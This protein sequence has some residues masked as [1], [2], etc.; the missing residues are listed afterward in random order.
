MWLDLQIFGFRALWSPYFMIFVI[1]M[2]LA[3]FLIT[4]PYRHKFDALA[5]QPSTKEQI[6]F[7][8]AMILLYAVKGAPIDL[9]SHIMLTAHMIQM[10]VYYLI[11]PILVL[12]G[13]PEWLWRKVLYQPV[14]K[15]FFK[16]FTM[17]LISLLMF[18]VLF[19]LYHLP[20]VFDFAKSS[21]FAH[22]ATSLI[23]LFAAFIMWFPIVAPIRD[24]DTISPLL[25]IAYIIGGTVLITP[26]CVLIIF[27]DVPLFDAYSAQGSWIQALSLCVPINVLD[28]LQS[29]ISGPSM[30]SPIDIMEDQQLG[31][32]IMKIVQE[33]VYGTMIARIFFKWFSKESLKIDP[34]PSNTP[35]E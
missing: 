18:N 30:F 3:Y 10:A 11:F 26:A 9:L 24:E 35:Q 8:L 14:I 33:I 22:T 29:S 12:Q 7:Y 2:G 25:K 5:E 1:A 16:L 17:P 28:G 15:P 23:I 34:L 31:G 20:A 6:S 27:A 13:I 32:I 4:G 21:Q 19:S